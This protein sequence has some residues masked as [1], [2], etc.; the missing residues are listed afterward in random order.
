MLSNFIEQE[1]SDT[2]LSLPTPMRA[3]LDRFRSFLLA[4]YSA[5]FGYYPPSAFNFQ[6]YQTMHEDFEALY[7]LLADKS[8]KSSEMA[9]AAAANA[10]CAL[11][12]LRSFDYRHQYSPLEH[13]LPL[14]PRQNPTTCPGSRSRGMMRLWR[15]DKPTLSQQQ[16]ARASLANASNWKEKVFQNDL[17]RA[18][19][20]FEDGSITS[21]N[22]GDRHEK[23]SLADARKV[24]WILAYAVYQ[25]LRSVTQRPEEAR[26]DIDAPYSLSVS[27]AGLPPWKVKRDLAKLLRRQTDL[28]IENSALMVWDH[29]EAIPEETTEP[30]PDTDHSALARKALAENHQ[31]NRRA[32][33]S[34]IFD[35][36][37]RRPLT[38][39][40]LNEPRGS[41]STA[42]RSMRIFKPARAVPSRAGSPAPRQAYHQIVIDGYGNGTNKVNFDDSDEAASSDRILDAGSD[43]TGSKSNL[44]AE[45]PPQSLLTEDSSVESP[46]CAET[47]SPVLAASSQGF[48]AALE[49]KPLRLLGRE[50]VSV[51]ELADSGSIPEPQTVE[52]DLA[53]T[54][55]EM[56]DYSAAYEAM[57]EDELKIFGLNSPEFSAPPREPFH[58]RCPEIPVRRRSFVPNGPLLRTSSLHTGRTGREAKTGRR[59]D[60][61]AFMDGPGGV[62]RE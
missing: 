49:P 3:H 52:Q 13:P 55:A 27:S 9:P 61:W 23:V 46:T 5:K 42:R 20:Q 10:A 4:F 11:Q 50:S 33:V 57:V 8:Y 31:V 38:S 12:H 60:E 41:R 34:D 14:L 45:S 26:F 7:D 59:A 19:K 40:S 17:V 58:R 44:S 1:L 22:S 30:K 36:Q 35:S 51:V 32:S 6:M 53:N 56:G 2:H 39:A 29:V 62:I 18:Y 37:A 25:V 16:A 28:S 54:G 43:S 24:R 15:G 47:P 48:V 21:P